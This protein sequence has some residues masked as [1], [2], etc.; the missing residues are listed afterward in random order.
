MFSV[1]L[2]L[3]FLAITQI[4]AALGP[5]KLPITKLVSFGDS[6]TDYV[7]AAAAAQAQAWPA[8]ASQDGGFSNTNVAVEGGTCNSS[9]VSS[10]GPVLQVQIPRYQVIALSGILIDDMRSTVFSAWIGSTDVSYMLF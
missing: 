1:T 10:L 5:T 4:G 3:G 8:F 2:T 9:M 7:A 6:Y